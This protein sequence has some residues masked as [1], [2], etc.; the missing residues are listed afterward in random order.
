MTTYYV[1][2]SGLQQFRRKTGVQSNDLVG[3]G[4]FVANALTRRLPDRPQFQIRQV[5][6][7]AVAVPMVHPFVRQQIPPQCGSHDSAVLED[8]ALGFCEVHYPHI[9]CV[10]R[11]TRP[12][13]SLTA[14]HLLSEC[15]SVGMAI[16][17]GATC[18]SHAKLGFRRFGLSA[19][20]PMGIAHDDSEAAHSLP[21]RGARYATRKCD[22]VKRDF[23]FVLRCQPIGVI[24]PSFSALTHGAILLPEHQTGAR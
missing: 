2:N 3:P 20:V 5:V 16:P 1:A 4:E 8:A 22:G 19:Y 14:G 15:Q 11:S 21:D 18:G 24:D 7:G 12:I 17:I 6:V 13:T 10:R 9:A 23:S